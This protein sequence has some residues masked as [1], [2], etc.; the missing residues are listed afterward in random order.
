MQSKQDLMEAEVNSKS[1][2]VLLVEDD[3]NFGR[4]LRDYLELNDFTVTLARDG[5]EGLAWFRK[6][7]FDLCLLDVMM[8][9]LDGFALAREI[10]KVNPEMPMLFLTAKNQKADIL[11]GFRLGADDYITKPFDSEVLLA[12]VKAI[13]NRKLS[14]ENQEENEFVVGKLKFN[15]KLRTIVN[16][17]N[18]NAQKL[19]P[20]EAELLKMLCQHKNDVLTREKA[21]KTIWKEDSYFTARSMDVFI[22]KLRKYLKE[23]PSL[24]IQNLHRHGFQL[25]EHAVVA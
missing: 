12:K 13:V 10:R 20:K 24:T 18:G 11:E 21:L 8:P 3:Q 9:K 25:S 15:F 7:S 5:I 6:A 19:S 4:V 16:T 17:E 14:L 1:L 2:T 22:V 23:D